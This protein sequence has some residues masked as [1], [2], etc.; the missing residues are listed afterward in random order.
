M[1]GNASA[2]EI[3]HTAL[4]W[5]K[6]NHQVALIT[7]AKTWGSS[8]RPVG[9]MLLVREDGRHLGSVS[10]GC[11]EEDLL[12]RYCNGEFA[13]QPLT[14]LKYGVTSEQA[15][16]FGLPCG[17][18][19][20]L[21]LENLIDQAWLKNILAT[22]EQTELIYRQIN[23]TNGEVTLLPANVDAEFSY[24]NGYMQQVFGPTWQLLLIGAG[25]LS[26]YVAQI[27][28]MLGYQVIVCDP[29]ETYSDNWQLPGTELIRIMPDDAVK[30]LIS[31]KRG[32]VV[33]LTHDPKLDDMALWEALQSPAFYIGALGSKRSSD[34]RRQRLQ[35]LGVS[36]EQLARLHA[37]VGLDIGSHTPAEIAV[38]VMAEITAMR[39][40][41]NL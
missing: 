16:R 9:S 30:Q 17:G 29:R 6:Q 7:V 23:L 26:H 32:I 2:P 37:P 3:L 15:H 4:A 24:A 38:A 22:I 40:G 5:L 13:Q 21:V 25:H 10:G 35:K 36:L 31:H 18:S 27:G 14:E 39:N 1:T 34:S 28:L 19:L 33:T 20:K 11:I 41:I 12:N 8:P